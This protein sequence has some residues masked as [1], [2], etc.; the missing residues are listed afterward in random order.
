MTVE[1]TGYGIS[2]EAAVQIRFQG[3]ADP[4][5]RRSLPGIWTEPRRSRR[6]ER[7]TSGKERVRRRRL[8]QN[9]SP[10]RVF[11]KTTPAGKKAPGNIMRKQGV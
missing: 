8:E 11:K 4:P 6:I 10:R 7:Q 1:R 2:A 5:S 3:A 9:K